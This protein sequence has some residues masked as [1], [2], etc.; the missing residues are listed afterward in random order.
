LPA[1][2]AEALASAAFVVA[3]AAEV[4]ADAA[5]LVAVVVADVT[6]DVNSVV[7]SAEALIFPSSRWISPKR[8]IVSLMLARAALSSWS[9]F[10]PGCCASG[11]IA[12]KSV[13]SKE[14]S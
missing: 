1:E 2:V 3:V 12:E 5:A 8:S 4:V 14:R 13:K 11:C 7:S 6:M 10:C 9:I